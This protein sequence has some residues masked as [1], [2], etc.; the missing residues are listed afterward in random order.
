[1]SDFYGTGI[2]GYLSTAFRTNCVSHAYI[3]V[4]ERAQLPALLR[5]CA[6]VCICGEHVVSDSCESCHKVLANLHQDVLYFPQDPSRMRI[7]VADMQYLVEESCKRP[8]DNGDCRV[9][10]INAA[11][12][13]NGV[14]SDIWQ[15]K[16]L[17]TL[18]EP[19]P[20]IF[21]FIGVTDS[22]ALLSTVRSRCQILKQPKLSVSAVSDVLAQ[23]GYEKSLCEVAAAVSEGNIEAAEAV[24]SDLSI[25]RAFDNAS[26]MLQNMTSTKNSLQFV[27]AALAEKESLAWFLK[28]L[29]LLL[30]ESIHFR[31]AENLC[32]L[33]SHRQAIEKICQNYTLQAAEVSIEKIAVAKR[34]LDENGN[35]A[36]VIDELAYTILE[37]KYRCRI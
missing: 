25:F 10:L 7:N 27:T 19:A 28:F 1:M 21:I 23:R 32:V 2:S 4:G 14:G 36:V 6:A 29:T 24:F 8:V 17:K 22:D 20:N 9:F 37:V 11:D 12:S 33:P 34:R 30:S 13:V 31:L 3:I 16:L 26:D 15:N 35:A 18:E 5:Q